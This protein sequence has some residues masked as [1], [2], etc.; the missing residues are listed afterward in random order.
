MGRP[1][2]IYGWAGKILKINLSKKE[3]KEEELTDDL[4][5]GYIGS[6]GFDAK[7][8]WDLVKPGIDPL[9]PENVLSLGAGLMTG[10]VFP[11]CGRMNVGC[12]SA[13]TGIYGYGNSGGYWPGRLKAAGYDQIVITG[14]SEAPVY[15]FIDENN[16]VI[17]DA[18]DLWGKSIIETEKIL[19]DK[20]GRDVRVAGIGQAG[21]NLVRTA[22]TM[23]DGSYAAHGGS[24][25]VWGSKNLK[26]I[27]VTGTK[28][29]NVKEQQLF[30]E[31]AKCE[32]KR[33]KDSTTRAFAADY[34]KYGTMILYDL[35]TNYIGYGADFRFLT[36][37]EMKSITSQNMFERYCIGYHAGCSNCLESCNHLWEVF[38]GPYAGTRTIGMR[39]G[40]T[41][42]MALGMGNN[43][44]SSLIKFH[45]LISH[46]G[47]CGKMMP[48]ALFFALELYEKGILTKEDTGGIEIKAGDHETIIELTHMTAFREGFGNILAEGPGGM[49]RII[50]GAYPHRHGVYGRTYTPTL[51]FITGSRGTDHL[52]GTLSVFQPPE[53][54]NKIYESL[55]KKI[56]TMKPPTEPGI[57][58]KAEWMLWEE[59]NKAVY[60]SL[61]RCILPAGGVLGGQNI[62]AELEDDPFGEERAKVL[63]ALVGREFSADEILKCG[64]RIM[65]LER[66]F[67]IRQ[68]AGPDFDVPPEREQTR[69]FDYLA[70]S[71]LKPGMMKDYIKEYHKARGWDAE[72]GAPTRAKLEEL[73]LGYVA[74]ELEANM[75][76]RPYEGPPLWPLDKYPSK[77]NRIKW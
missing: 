54:R 7:F 9:G 56:P 48:T 5:F 59:D 47:L 32:A 50:E 8:L 71:E 76:Y 19:R 15:I 35:L 3:F 4:A 51:A 34:K 55:S 53:N 41:D 62:S 60:D 45:Q 11:E 63:T 21:E 68:G 58:G 67:N 40:S 36:E 23:V 14:K 77:G 74:D 12:L 1:E 2:T 28:K 43:N 69:E 72:T 17:K 57:K 22:C 10:T 20:H 18:G 16:V 25:A 42:Y 30:F 52:S 70:Y 37:E 65:N 13:L 64:E 73:G 29:I 24:G 66:A 26:A 27:A 38:C 31:M 6:R 33:I 44:A 75:P 61:G 49:A 39:F 46:Y